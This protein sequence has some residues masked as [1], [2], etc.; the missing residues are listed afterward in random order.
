MDYKKPTLERLNRRAASLRESWYAKRP[1]RYVIV[2]DFL[3]PEFAE[4]I[5][6][7]YPRPEADD[8]DGTTYIHQRKKLT[9][10]S[11]FTEPIQSFFDLTATPEFRDLIGDITGIPELIDDPDLVGG[12]LHQILSG[13]FLDVHVDYN[14]HPVTKLYRRLNLLLYMNKNWKPEFEGYL[15]LWD[16]DAQRQL[17]HV[18]PIF[19]RAVMFET[20]EL[21]Y[22]GH[23]RPLNVPSG[24][25][26]QSL[27]I[28]YYTEEYEQGRLAPEHNTLY[29]QTTGVQ[30]YLKTTRAASQAFVERIVQNGPS[31]LIK[32]ALRKGHRRLKGLPPENK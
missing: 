25:T 32:D 14:L 29:K 9:K 2:D 16:L 10:R 13:G 23:P 28:Y 27:A 31:E 11:G 6:A 26:R 4:A 12:G 22:H 20:T 15:E 18:A 21:S 8:W 24:V 30:G 19:N 5:L 1:F 7:A 17:E 3:P